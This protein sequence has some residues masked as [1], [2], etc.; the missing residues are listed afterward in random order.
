MPK[1]YNLHDIVSP[2]QIHDLCKGYV[3]L[4]VIN[5]RCNN[6]PF[7]LIFPYFGTHA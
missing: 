3:V 6:V 4:N 5:I 2:V 1:S 7:N